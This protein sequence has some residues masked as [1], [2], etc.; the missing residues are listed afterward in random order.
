MHVCLLLSRHSASG[1]AGQAGQPSPRPLVRTL[2]TGALLWNVGG[3][4][5]L[6]ETKNCFLLIG[7]PRTN[8]HRPDSKRVSSLPDLRRRSRVAFWANRFKKYQDCQV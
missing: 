4:Y 6:E 5:R 1:Q 3:C 2:L 7:L 8:R